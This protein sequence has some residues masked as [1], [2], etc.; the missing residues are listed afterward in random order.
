MN[1]FIGPC[2]GGCFCL[3]WWN[4]IYFHCWMGW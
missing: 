3:L 2:W 1:R 4:P